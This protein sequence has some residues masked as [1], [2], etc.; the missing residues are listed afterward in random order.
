MFHLLLALPCLIVILRFLI[1]LAWPLWVT[2]VVSAALLLVSQHHLLTL[3]AFGSMFSPEVPRAVILVVNTLF[4]AMIFLALMQLVTDTITLLLA[5]ARRRK[6][7]I[8]ASL[9]YTLA[10]VAIGLA[11]FGVSQA[12]RLPPLKE[13]EITLA[14]LPEA[15]D[16]YEIIHLTDLHISRLFEAPWV[17]RIVVKTNALAPDVILITGDLIDGALDA[18]R[19]A[20]APLQ[21]LTAPDGVYVS[22]GNHEYY[23][24]YEEWMGHYQS[25]GMQILANQHAVIE[26]DGTALV[27]AGVTDVSAED[28]GYPAPDITQALEGA[29][30]DATVI[31]LDHQPRNAR[32]A[33]AQGVDLQLSGHTHGGM[34]VGFDHIVARANNGFVSGLYDLGGMTLYVN[35]GTGLWPGFALRLGKPSELT[36]ITL[37]RE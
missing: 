24:G 28:D 26:R 34:M 36:R 5:L 2:C 29:P 15:F 1:P 19:D 21:A 14:D 3:F 13:V 11:A 6:L 25:Q 33:A 18:R 32:E 30:D 35:N 9:R 12:A 17:E 37:R 16:G 7:Y 4:G 23:F 22:P 8:A 10:V 20:V 27:L 31:L